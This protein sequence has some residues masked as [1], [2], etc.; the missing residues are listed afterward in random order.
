MEPNRNTYTVLL[1]CLARRRKTFDGFQVCKKQPPASRPDNAGHAPVWPALL[2]VAPFVCS[3]VRW[4]T[5]DKTTRRF[6]DRLGCVLSTKHKTPVPAAR[7]KC[8]LSNDING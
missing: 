5:E 2:R 8:C 7:T 1:N 6:S 3:S 4:H